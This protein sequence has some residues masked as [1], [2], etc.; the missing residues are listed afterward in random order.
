M[1]IPGSVLRQVREALVK[2]QEHSHGSSCNYAWCKEALTALDAAMSAPEPEQWFPLLGTGLAIRRALLDEATAQRNHGQSLT[3][4]AERGGLS[5]CEAVAVLNRRD[6]KRMET[7]AAL[8][9]LMEA[10]QKL[11]APPKEP[12]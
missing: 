12:T 2:I 11:P 1:N 10:T 7:K 5:P 3:R 9:E 8:L 4:L 6:W